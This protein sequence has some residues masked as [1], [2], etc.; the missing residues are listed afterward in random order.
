MFNDELKLIT[1]QIMPDGIGNQKKVPLY[2]TILCNIQSTTRSE[3]YNY[4]DS[5]FRPEYVADINACEYENETEAEFRGEIYTITRTY[6][7][8]R[9]LLELTL[10]R[11]IQR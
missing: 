7:V 2:K 11:Q 5:E 3:F 1:Y 9:D 4:G 10:S 6:E 8:D